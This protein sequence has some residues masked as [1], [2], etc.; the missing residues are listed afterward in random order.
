[1][2]A[3]P[4]RVMAATVAS[5]AQ[6]SD[7]GSAFAP[8]HGYTTDT[9]LKDKRFKVESCTFV[10]KAAL[11]GHTLLPVCTRMICWATLKIKEVKCGL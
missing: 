7:Q 1:M 11:V 5:S 4:D 9:L 6:T 10:Q 3:D 2:E 8:I